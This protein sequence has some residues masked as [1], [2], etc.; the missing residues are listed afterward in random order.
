[1]LC[2]KYIKTSRFV[3]IKDY[4]NVLKLETALFHCVYDTN[5]MLYC[6]MS[7]PK[8]VFLKCIE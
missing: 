5:N 6:Y 3:S 8:C 1:M 7:K 2:L 4:I